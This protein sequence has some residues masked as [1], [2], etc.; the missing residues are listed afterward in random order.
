[1]RRLQR[2]PEMLPCVTITIYI[3]NPPPTV[4]DVI[5]MIGQCTAVNANRDGTCLLQIY[6]DG[7]S[8]FEFDS[9]LGQRPIIK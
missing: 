6:H 1:M 4:P 2:V 9:R 5:S 8:H 7:L 3:N